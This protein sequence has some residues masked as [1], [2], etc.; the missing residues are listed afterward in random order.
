MLID[1]SVN[2]GNFSGNK[3]DGNDSI[4]DRYL[5]NDDNCAFVDVFLIG[6]VW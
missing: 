4:G 5:D 3:G 6:I 1:I 2:L